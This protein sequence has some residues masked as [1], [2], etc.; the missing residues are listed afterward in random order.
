MSLWSHVCQRAK[1]GNLI[2]GGG[3][4]I[5][6]SLK[7]GSEQHVCVT[8]RERDRDRESGSL[9]SHYND[10]CSCSL[11][12]VSILRLCCLKVPS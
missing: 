8:D 4:A 10:C 5:S 7:V 1:G 11:P 12:A 3:T 6:G 2:E 9:P